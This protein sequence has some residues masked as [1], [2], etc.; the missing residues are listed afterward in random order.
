MTALIRRM[1][2]FA[3]AATLAAVFAFAYAAPVR[4]ALPVGDAGAPDRALGSDHA[5]SAPVLPNAEG[6][7]ES[8]EV[9]DE[10]G[11]AAPGALSPF[12]FVRQ[13]SNR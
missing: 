8:M 2:P 6:E 13:A 5:E 9:Q 12:D 1:Y 3:S 10:A 4:A 7:P 11:D